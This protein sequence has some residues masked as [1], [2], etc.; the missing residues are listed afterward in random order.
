MLEFF[1]DFY[2]IWVP[3]LYFSNEKQSE[4]HQ[5]TVPNILVR[6]KYDGS[7]TFSQRVTLRNSCPMDLIHYPLDSQLCKMFMESCEYRSFYGVSYFSQCYLFNCA[8]S[9]P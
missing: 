7:I 8:I 3:D 5:V 4:L 2:K 1:Q 9:C 6:I